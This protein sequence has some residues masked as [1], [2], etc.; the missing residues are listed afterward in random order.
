[1]KHAFATL[2]LL[3]TA[4]CQ[5]PTPTVEMPKPY[6]R[7]GVRVI[8]KE[9]YGPEGSVL[10]ISGEAVNT[11]KETLKTCTLKFDVLDFAEYKVAEAAAYREDF[12]PGEHWQFQ[13]QF[14][15]PYNDEFDSVHA[16]PVSV[17]K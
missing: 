17:T 13:A 7:N 9:L 12:A 14:S 11:G 3:T 8:L 5:A 6:E 10:G 4:A 16:G 15:M 2:I 1:M